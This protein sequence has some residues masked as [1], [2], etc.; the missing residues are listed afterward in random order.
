MVTIMDMFILVLNACYTHADTHAIMVMLGPIF[1]FNGYAQTYAQ[2]LYSCT[3]HGDS[4]VMFILIVILVL[5]GYVQ[6]FMVKG[7]VHA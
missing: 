7:H 3:H 5:N 1:L 4:M 6:L 2:W